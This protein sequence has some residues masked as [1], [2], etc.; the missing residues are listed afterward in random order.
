MRRNK[1]E[2][3]YKDMSEADRI[4]Y[5]YRNKLGGK[6]KMRQFVDYY[7]FQTIVILVIL[8]I[9]AGSL[10]QCATRVDPDITV[11]LLGESYAPDTDAVEAMSAALGAYIEDVNGD[12][13]VQGQLINVFVPDE[14]TGEYYTSVM[15]K[16]MI[17]LTVGDADLVIL[18]QPQYQEL[19]LSGG[20]AYFSEISDIVGDRAR[21]KYTVRFSDTV[22]AQDEAL[23]AIPGDYL[24]ALRFEDLSKSGK[25]N[26]RYQARRA[27]SIQLLQNIMA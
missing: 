8:A 22:F 5:D 10:Y 7:L 4:K 14:D 13:H 2:V 25:E 3:D 18:S 26:E 21:D 16:R 24:I 15:Q 20:E 17:E 19:M 23:G 27:A 11:L 12:G 6:A 1:T 9:L